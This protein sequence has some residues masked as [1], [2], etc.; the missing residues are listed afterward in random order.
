[1][2]WAYI[3]QILGLHGRFA[4]LVFAAKA[5]GFAL[6]KISSACFSFFFSDNLLLLLFPLKMDSVPRQGRVIRRHLKSNW[7]NFWF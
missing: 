4:A 5:R 7:G 6:H 2:R 3:K 1:M